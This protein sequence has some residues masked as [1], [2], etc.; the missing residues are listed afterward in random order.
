[1]LEATTYEVELNLMKLFRCGTYDCHRS[2]RAGPTSLAG[3]S[4]IRQHYQGKLELLP[5]EIGCS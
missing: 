2:T 5:V 3:G 4:E 1:M